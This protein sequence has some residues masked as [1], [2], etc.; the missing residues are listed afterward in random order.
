MLNSDSSIGAS[1]CRFLAITSIWPSFWSMRIGRPVLASAQIVISDSRV[2]GQEPH[3][4]A[5]V[6]VP[7]AEVLHDEMGAVLELDDDAS[8]LIQVVRASRAGL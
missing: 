6:D 7:H 8:E 4:L 2:F 3:R 1:N 5:A